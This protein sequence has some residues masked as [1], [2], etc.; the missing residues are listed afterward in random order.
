MEL[1][2]IFLFATEYDL[3]AEALQ[4][5]G[6]SEGTP[7]THPGQG[8]AC[9][10]FYFRNAY[11]ELVW[12]A[13]EKEARDSGM[14]KAKLWERAQYHQTKFCPLGLCFRAKN[15]PGKLP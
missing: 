15:L 5:F 1:D 2:H 9:R 4:M 3:L 6:L 14:A 13:N 12:I 8:T 11:L 10:R 7:N